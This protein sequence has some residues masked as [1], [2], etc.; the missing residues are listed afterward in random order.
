MLNFILCEDKFKLKPEVNT[1]TYAKEWFSW[2]K[3]N[4]LGFC[5]HS[6]SCHLLEIHNLSAGYIFGSGI[7]V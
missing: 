4:N 7:A 5:E 1:N 2:K 3:D 6:Y